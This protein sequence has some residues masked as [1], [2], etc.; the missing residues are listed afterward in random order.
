MMN[1]RSFDEIPPIFVQ[2]EIQKTG[3]STTFEHPGE[4]LTESDS[5]TK[6]VEDLSKV[7]Y[8]FL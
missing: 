2:T 1:Q 3:L 6:S 7:P 5:P 4:I 8:Q